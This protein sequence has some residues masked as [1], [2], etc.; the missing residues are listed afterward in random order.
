MSRND[1]TDRVRE[2]VDRERLAAHGRGLEQ[3]QARELAIEAA[4]V[5]T[6]DPLLIDLKS[7]RCPPP[8]TG[9]VAEEIKHSVRV[10]L[11]CPD[12]AVSPRPCEPG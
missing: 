2:R 10:A 1:R 9:G 8:V 3:R 7:D 6:D 12:P 4:C 5:R 11:E